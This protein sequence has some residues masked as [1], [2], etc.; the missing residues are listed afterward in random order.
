MCAGRYICIYVYTAMHVFV[1]MYICIC[2]CEVVLYVIGQVYERGLW[3]SSPHT[4]ALVN[5][6]F[7]FVYE[8][9]VLQ[10]RGRRR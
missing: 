8:V 1:Y 5:I 2:I 9:G 7:V 4:L 6:A 3:S 10:R